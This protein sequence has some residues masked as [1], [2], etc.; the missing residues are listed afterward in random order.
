MMA[1]KNHMLGCKG[2]GNPAVPGQ[3][4]ILRFGHNEPYASGE[5][6]DVAMAWRFPSTYYTLCVDRGMTY[7][8]TD[9]QCGSQ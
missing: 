9:L 6:D 8:A 2:R 1:Q 4:G 5:V 3:G 7:K